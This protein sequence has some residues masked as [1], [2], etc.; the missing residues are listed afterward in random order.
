MSTVHVRM[1]GE[2]VPG[3]NDLRFH[4]AIVGPADR[5]RKCRSRALALALRRAD[6]F[7]RQPLSGMPRRS[8]LLCW[9][10]VS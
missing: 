10:P 9:M 1:T 6:V 5:S 8:L 7:V 2:A 4:G 3:K